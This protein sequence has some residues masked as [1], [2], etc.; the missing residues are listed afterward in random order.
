MMFSIGMRGRAWSVV[1]ARV[2]GALLT[3]ALFAGCASPPSKTDAPST[4]PAVVALVEDAHASSDQQRHDRAAAQLERALRIE[5]TNPVLWHELAQVYL[6]Q[7]GLDEAIQFATKSNTL[8]EDAGMESA[9]WE[10]IAQA[11]NRMGDR[12]R[13]RRARQKANTE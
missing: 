12:D 11:Y 2:V 3:I 10:L 9:N 5:P 4:K 6:D 7:G 1:R 8:T 13:A